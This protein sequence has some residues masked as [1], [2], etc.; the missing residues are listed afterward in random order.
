MLTPFL[1]LFRAYRYI[2][3]GINAERFGIDPVDGFRT[4]KSCFE[5]DENVMTDIIAEEA[6]QL[7]KRRPTYVSNF[8]CW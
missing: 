5:F 2:A 6:T 7:G 4:E 3:G 1:F 8:F